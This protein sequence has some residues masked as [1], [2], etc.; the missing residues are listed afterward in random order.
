M[1]RVATWKNLAI[2]VASLLAVAGI[3]IVTGNTGFATALIVVAVV[4]GVA[5]ALLIAAASAR[6]RRAA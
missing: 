5:H 2:A 1:E 6:R 3:C 4:E